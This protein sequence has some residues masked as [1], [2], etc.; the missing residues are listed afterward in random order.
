MRETFTRMA[1][2]DALERVLLGLEA[3]RRHFQGP[4][5]V[6]AVVMRG[7]NDHEVVDFARLARREGF[8][9]RF[10]EFMPLDAD[11]AW[12]LEKMVPGAEIREAIE[13]EYPLLPDPAQDPR[14]PSRDYVFADGAGGKVG[15]I[16]SVTEPFCESCNRVRITADGKFRTCLFSVVETDVRA[17]LRGGAEDAE[18]ARVLRE[19]IWV[20]EPGH[21]IN[22]PGFVFASRSMSQIGG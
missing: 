15:F 7:L 11:R 18:I 4:V 20:K 22:Q 6:N 14:A 13:R 17:L 16:D 2:R 21:R 10:I 19:A 8:E 1:R 12:S 5:K 3:A 9:V